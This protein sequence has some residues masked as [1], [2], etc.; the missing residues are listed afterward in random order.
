MK[1]INLT[2]ISAAIILTA[3][4]PNSG[5]TQKLSTK[6]DSVSY[7]LGTFNALQLQKRLRWE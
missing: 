6:I 5:F 2:V 3:C 4:N 7:S 1:R